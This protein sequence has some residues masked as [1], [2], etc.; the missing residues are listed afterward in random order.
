[1][2]K[3]DD[4]T[5]SAHVSRRQL[6]RAAAVTAVGA[7]VLLANAAPAEAKMSQKG[8]GYQAT[9]K[10]DQKCSNCSLFKPPSA[11]ILVSGTISPDGWCR[12]WRKAA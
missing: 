11:C 4:T 5:S 8:A 10:G 1:M 7:T 9:P 3:Q 2:T 6:F 12:F